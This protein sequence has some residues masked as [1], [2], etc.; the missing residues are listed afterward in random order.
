MYFNSQVSLAPA[1]FIPTI[2]TWNTT[3]KLM[4]SIPDVLICSLNPVRSE[5]LNEVCSAT[6]CQV[7]LKPYGKFCNMSGSWTGNQA[8]ADRRDQKTYG[9][10]SSNSALTLKTILIGPSAD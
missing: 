4:T 1:P 8:H 6:A 9:A 5:G 2:S 7:P 10:S 3:H